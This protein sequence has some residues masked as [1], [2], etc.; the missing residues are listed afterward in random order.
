MLRCIW[1]RSHP[2]ATCQRISTGF[3]D[4]ITACW[5]QTIHWARIASAIWPE[6]GLRGVQ[7][8][9]WLFLSQVRFPA[10]NVLARKTRETW[11]VIVETIEPHCAIIGS[12]GPFSDN[13]GSEF[14]LHR[15][16]DSLFVTS[17]RVKSNTTVRVTP[18][19]VNVCIQRSFGTSVHEASPNVGI[20]TKA[21]MHDVFP[22]RRLLF[23][24]QVSFPIKTFEF[25]DWS[26][27]PRLVHRFQSQYSWMSSIQVH[28]LLDYFQRVLDVFSVNKGVVG[29]LLIEMPHPSSI[30]NRPMLEGNLVYVFRAE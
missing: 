14:T 22:V 5:A 21:I 16:Q 10:W 30:T 9:S 28:N 15:S 27:L 11:K 12:Q 25:L 29:Y 19:L 17:I 7:W 3:F 4:P 13:N 1:W 18:G 24:D 20:Q 2:I 8:H 6:Q 23:D 26:K